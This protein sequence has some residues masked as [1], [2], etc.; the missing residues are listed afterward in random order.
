[1]RMHHHAA[2]RV[3]STAAVAS[4]SNPSRLRMECSNIHSQ[5]SVNPT[6]VTAFAST[7][8]HGLCPP[9]R[10]PSLNASPTC[11]TLAAASLSPAVLTT[12]HS[13]TSFSS[14]WLHALLVVCGA[15]QE[16]TLARGQHH[17]ASTTHAPVQRVLHVL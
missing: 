3:A 14:G 16:S 9:D 17:A 10:W 4:S 7:R 15:K 13:G 8:C 5:A 11:S 12:T 6:P 1:M 2:V